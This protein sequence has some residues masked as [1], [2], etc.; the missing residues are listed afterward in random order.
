MV[1]T[2]TGRGPVALAAVLVVVAAATRG[3]AG[4]FMRWLPDTLAAPTPASAV[5]HAGVVASGVLVLLRHGSDVATSS[6]AALALAVAAVVLGGI[7]CIVAEAVMTTRPD[8][9]GQLAVAMTTLLVANEEQ[10]EGPRF[11]GPLLIRTRCPDPSP[12]SS[13]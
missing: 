10:Q 4:P 3:A 8:T 7:T 12:N 9:K 13:L 1:L 2:L 6:D 5:L 11:P